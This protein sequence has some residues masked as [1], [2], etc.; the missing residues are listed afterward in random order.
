MSNL[1]QQL[2][3]RSVQPLLL[4][5]LPSAF[6]SLLFVLF[7][8]APSLFVFDRLAIE[9][10][11]YWRLLTCHFVHSDFNHLIMNMIACSMILPFIG[12]YKSLIVLSVFLILFVSAGLW[13]FIPG[14]EFYCGAS[15]V[16]NGL[17]FWALWRHWRKEPHWCFGVIFLGAVSKT[18]VET[19]NNQPVFDIYKWSALPESHLIGMFGALVIMLIYSVNI[20]GHIIY[21]VILS[22]ALTGYW[23][24]N[25]LEIA[26]S[27]SAYFV[28]T[29]CVLWIALV[30]R[31]LP[32]NLHWRP[33]IKEATNDLIFLGLVQVLL[34]L[35]LTLSVV[36]GIETITGQSGWQLGM[37]WPH[38]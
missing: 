19:F 15:A 25:S 36:S 30:E 14:L 4:F 24:L 12:N 7:G 11:E 2:F 21:P 20:V 28:V 5:C 29:V 10:G 13:L 34:P 27:M 33:D 9:N 8:S 31:V 3:G 6:L 23:F 17:L 18:V 22:T 16:L 26:T 37:S 1:Y 32:E 38:H 35:G